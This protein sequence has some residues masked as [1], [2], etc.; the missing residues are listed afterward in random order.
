MRNG[1]SVHVGSG[2]K[3]GSRL[4][5]RHFR[6]TPNN[7]LMLD[8]M[9]RNIAEQVPQSRAGV[10]RSARSPRHER[11]G[12]ERLLERVGGNAP[13][14]GKGPSVSLRLLGL[15]LR[16]AA[17]AGETQ[18][19]EPICTDSYWAGRLKPMTKSHL[20]LV[21]PGTVKR[22]VMPK[23]RRNGDL[24]TRE[25]MTEAEVEQLMKAA[26]GDRHGHRDATMILVAYR[27][28]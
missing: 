6:L 8:R 9:G 3:A 19:Q 23:R 24:R 25:Y 5:Q 7:G 28:A 12:R 15:P 14:R 17:A 22:T 20:T 18:S 13:D 26:T 21:P 2:S 10:V 4:G 1:G 11:P 27:P 16:H